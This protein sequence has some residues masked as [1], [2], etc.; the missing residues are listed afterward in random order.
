MFTSTKL[1]ELL[2]SE[3][4]AATGTA[5]NNAGVVQ[6]LVEV[7]QNDKGKNEMPWGTLYHFPTALNHVNQIGWKDNAFVILMTTRYEAQG[8]VD[9][10]R[11]RPQESSS[12]ARTSRAPFGKHA[13]EHFRFQTRILCEKVRNLHNYSIRTLLNN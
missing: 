6:E 12:K 1:L 11:K 3:G 4:F 10:L 13:I 7:K 5:R 8:T 9:R 2:R